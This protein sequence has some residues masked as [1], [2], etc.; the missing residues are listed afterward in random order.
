MGLPPLTQIAIGGFFLQIVLRVWIVSLL[1]HLLR[2]FCH[3]SSV[4][5]SCEVFLIQKQWMLSIVQKSHPNSVVSVTNNSY[6]I[7][8]SGDVRYK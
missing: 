2:F 6:V 4:L 3:V 1:V 8:F 5:L 7:A